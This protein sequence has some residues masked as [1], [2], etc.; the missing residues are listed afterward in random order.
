MADHQSRDS[1]PPAPSLPYTA[2]GCLSL[3]LAEESGPGYSQEPP[4]NRLIAS[5]PQLRKGVAARKGWG[6]GTA[7]F[8]FHFLWPEENAQLTCRV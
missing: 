8:S 2:G 6:W 3:C 5:L 7:A 1:F 4:L